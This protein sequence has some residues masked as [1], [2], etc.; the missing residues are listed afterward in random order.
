MQCKKVTFSRHAVQRMFACGLAEPPVASL[1]VSG[2]VIEDYPTDFP[3]PSCLLLGV[4]GGLPVHV[5]VARD[6]T[7][8]TCIVVTVYVPSTLRWSADYRVRKQP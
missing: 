1:V 3:Y 8:E 5:V 2:D 6:P 4:I 7:S